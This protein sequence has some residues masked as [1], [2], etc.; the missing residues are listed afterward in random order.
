MTSLCS[1]LSG[2]HIDRYQQQGRARAA[3]W[4]SFANI[5]L[6]LG[7]LGFFKYFNFFVECLGD[8][9]AAVGLGVSMPMLR[10]VLPVGI[11]FYT[12]QAL[13]YSIDVYR[14]EMKPTRDWVAFFA[15]V[16]FFPQLV[17]GPI[18]RARN[19]LPQ[20]ERDRVIGSED[21]WEGL[22]LVFWGLF[23]KV[24]VA[25]NLAVLVDGTFAVEG[26]SGGA[27][28]MSVYAFAFQIYCDFS[29]YSDMARGLARMMGIDLMVNFR[30]PYFAKNPKEFWARWHI[31]LSTW[32]KDYI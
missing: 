18:E 7:I 26:M 10:I 12:F 30:N 9:L 13:S 31:S 8:V 15:F 27:A 25:D 1:W 4:V 22:R 19:L 6:N 20:I 11:S 5:A 14:G 17:A 3:W 21:V 2:L 16:S 24:V 23:K 29:G 32:L 28:L